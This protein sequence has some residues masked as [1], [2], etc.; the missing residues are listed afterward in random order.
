MSTRST[1][2]HKEYFQSGITFSLF[3]DIIYLIC[4]EVRAKI[5]FISLIL[6][7]YKFPN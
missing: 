6:N 4:L 7:N 1:G 3:A 2:S 5:V